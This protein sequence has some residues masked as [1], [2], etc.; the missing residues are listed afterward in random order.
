MENMT[1]IFKK[2]L[3]NLIM[4]SLALIVL[5][6]CTKNH[7]INKAPSI[8]DIDNKLKEEIDLSTMDIGNSEK[9]EKLYG[10][11]SEELEEFLLYTPKTNIEVNEIGIFKVKDSKDI[12]IIKGKIEERIEGQ[13]DIFKDYLPEEYYLIEKDVLKTKDKY[14]L[15]IISE[16]G[17]IIEKIFDE[18]FK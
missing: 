13:A 18:S 11:N 8:K 3:T 4:I 9:L 5:T 7:V 1:K 15:F 10:I 6:S 16:D 2:T 17:E 14:I 12:D